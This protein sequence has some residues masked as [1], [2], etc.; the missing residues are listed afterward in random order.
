LISSVKDT[1]DL[2]Y[3]SLTVLASRI[4]NGSF[5][6]E[7]VFLLDEKSLNNLL[8]YYGGQTIEVPKLSDLRDY[9]YGILIYYYYDIQGLSWKK[10][11]AKIGLEFNAELSYKLR[12][13]RKDVIKSLEGIKIPK[14]KSG[15]ES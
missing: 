7:L 10:S 1:S 3:L 6:P 11:V 2:Y 4:S 8:Y 12:R 5:L 14:M 13:L 9:L 15:D